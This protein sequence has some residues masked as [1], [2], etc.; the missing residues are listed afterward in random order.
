ME[1][2]TTIVKVF[3]YNN[4]PGEVNQPSSVNYTI[5]CFLCFTRLTGAQF[6]DGV[7]SPI[8]FQ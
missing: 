5:H 2:G 3:V 8:N 4:I 1:L 7:V 6:A